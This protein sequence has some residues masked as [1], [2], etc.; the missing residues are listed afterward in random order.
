MT[1][2]SRLVR[3]IAGLTALV[4]IGGCGTSAP[5]LIGVVVPEAGNAYARYCRAVEQAGGRTVLIPL[6]DEE[7]LAVFVSNLD[8]VLL[9]GGADLP[10]DLY[11]EEAH[12]TVRLIERERAEYLIA[13]ARLAVNGQTPVFGI[14][15]GQQVMNVARGG[16]LIQD[17]PSEVEGALV[18]RGDGAHHAVRVVEGSRLAGIVGTSLEVNS[19]HHQAVETLGEGLVVTARSPDGVIEAIELAGE[20]FVVVVQWHPERMLDEPEQRALFRAFVE[21]CR[22][23]R[24]AQSA[25]E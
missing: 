12:P 6:L 5:P 10:P 14:C 11:G 2:K 15:L 23:E 1:G 18:H 24:S 20:R 4:I 25:R 19:S 7:E 22:R 21:A 3:V 17:I 9:V 8:G 13:V 16:T